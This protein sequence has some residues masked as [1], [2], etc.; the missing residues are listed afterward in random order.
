M[1]F[2]MFFRSKRDNRTIGHRHDFGASGGV[3]KLVHSSPST[4]SKC[5]SLAHAASPRLFRSHARPKRNDFPFGGTKDSPPNLQFNMFLFPKQ[6]EKS[7]LHNWGVG[8]FFLRALHFRIGILCEHAT[9]EARIQLPAVVCKSLMFRTR[10]S[11]R[12]G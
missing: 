5:L 10:R 6:S 4:L 1:C 9:S 8:F 2:I 11:A 3:R 12:V 7:V